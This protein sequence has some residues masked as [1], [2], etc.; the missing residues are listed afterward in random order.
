VR[1][2]GREKKKKG[3]N[4]FLPPHSREKGGKGKRKYHLSTR[5]RERRK[6]GGDRFTLFY[7]PYYHYLKGRK[8]RKITGGGVRKERKQIHCRF[9]AYSRSYFPKKKGRGGRR[10]RWLS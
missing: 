10:A 2:E 7:P 9:S 8:S 5:I 6:G 4:L 1:S 3:K